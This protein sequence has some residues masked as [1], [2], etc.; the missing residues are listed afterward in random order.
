MLDFAPKVAA[1]SF[2]AF[3]PVVY[4]HRVIVFSTVISDNNIRPF[5]DIFIIKLVKIA[6]LL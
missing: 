5:G 1:Q 3:N 6:E 2:F 4:Y